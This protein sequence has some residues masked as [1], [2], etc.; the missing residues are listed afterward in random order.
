[1]NTVL[2]FVAGAF[3]IGA[4]LSIKVE[5]ADKFEIRHVWK[6]KRKKK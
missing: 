6:E 4:I 3:V 2:M 1:M 5:R